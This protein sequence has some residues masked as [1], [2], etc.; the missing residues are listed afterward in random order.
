VTPSSS[1]SSNVLTVAWYPGETP[2]AGLP[3]SAPVILIGTSYFQNDIPNLGPI[4]R[5]TEIW[6]GWQTQVTALGYTLDFKNGNY[7]FGDQAAYQVRKKDEEHDTKREKTLLM[8][9]RSIDYTTGD[10]PLSTLRGLWFWAGV[11]SEMNGNAPTRSDLDD[12]VQAWCT[13]NI[14]DNE[15]R[16][17]LCS[18]NVKRH[19]GE[20]F[21]PYTLFGQQQTTKLWGLDVTTYTVAGKEIS[22]VHDPLFDLEGWH[23]KLLGFV[24]SPNVIVRRNKRGGAKKFANFMLP[25]GEDLFHQES[26]YINTET[27][28]VKWAYKH[29]RAMEGIEVT[30]AALL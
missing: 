13:G 27:L 14:E 8:G 2:P 28:E 1:T 26:G 21:Y 22:F 15:K 9:Q 11:V 24:V 16:V 23:D 17:C 29:V 19:V 12:F 25:H 20:V 18:L 6:N 7:W 10:S 3:S 4:V 5:T 30:A